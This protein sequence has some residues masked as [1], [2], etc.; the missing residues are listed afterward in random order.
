MQG[1]YCAEC[2]YSLSALAEAGTCPEC[3]QNYTPQTARRRPL[4]VTDRLCK[5]IGRQFQRAPIFSPVIA[6]LT[7]VFA[8][9]L[10]FKPL[11]VPGWFVVLWVLTGG[12]LWVLIVVVKSILFLEPYT[13]AKSRYWRRVDRMR[14]FAAPVIYGLT[15][16][17][18]LSGVGWKARWAMSESRMT[19]TAESLIG[20]P[21]GHHFTSKAGQP[22]GEWFVLEHG[23]PAWLSWDYESGIAGD[24][25]F[26]MMVYKPGRKPG[27]LSSEWVSIGPSPFMPFQALQVIEV[28]QVGQDWWELY[29][30]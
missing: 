27:S 14:W 2:S 30:W 13:P 28:R 10:C 20:Q 19:A 16:L 25:E 5:A 23:E 3:G 15:L 8:L 24:R 4:T 6:L 12:P 22:R 26:I 29:A 18:I 11:G 1:R 7:L 21:A 9:L 17:L